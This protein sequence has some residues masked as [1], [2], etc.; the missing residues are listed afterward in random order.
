[1]FAGVKQNAEKGKS[2]TASECSHVS[3][4]AFTSSSASS[5]STAVIRDEDFSRSISVTD[6]TVNPQK[7]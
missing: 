3:F 4:C 1:M 2:S 6:K 5:V 7:K